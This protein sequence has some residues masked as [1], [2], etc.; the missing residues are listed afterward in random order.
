MRC[1]HQTNR[2]EAGH[3]PPMGCPYCAGRWICRHG[4]G[5]LS[6]ALHLP[7]PEPAPA[8]AP[9]PAA[10]SLHSTCTLALAS[11]RSAREHGTR[12]QCYTRLYLDKFSAGGRCTRTCV[13]CICVRQSQQSAVQR[14]AHVQARAV[15]VLI[16]ASP[17]PGRLPCRLLKPLWQARRHAASNSHFGKAAIHTVPPV[18]LPRARI[19]SQHANLGASSI[20]TQ[21]N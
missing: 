14:N 7:A 12:P 18:L 21:M 1:T 19:R 5:C 10:S 9:A 8:P 11:A 2:P 3:R 13:V 6:R 15:P 4:R 17:R 16:L 20:T